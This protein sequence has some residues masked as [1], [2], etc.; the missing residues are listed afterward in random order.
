MLLSRSVLEKFRPPKERNAADWAESYAYLPDS[1]ANRGKFHARPYQ[2]EILRAMSIGGRRLHANGAPINELILLKSVQVGYTQMVFNAIGY[3]IHQR[4]CPIGFYVP[5]TDTAQTFGSK[6]F[7]K[8]LA[9]QKILHKLVSDKLSNDGKSSTTTKIFPSGYFSI[10]SANKSADVASSSMKLIFGDEIDKYEHLI[11]GEGKP[12]ELIRNRA[13]EH[14]D[15]LVV[16]GSTPR[17]NYEESQIYQLY[18]GSDKRRFHVRCP[19]CNHQQYLAWPQ[20][21]PN[22]KN[23]YRESGFECIKCNK[24]FHE[25][26]KYEMISQGQWIGRKDK[27]PDMVPGRAGFYIWAAYSFSPNLTWPQIARRY[28][29]CNHDKGKRIDFYNNVVGLPSKEK[30]QGTVL[31]TEITAQKPNALYE[32]THPP[33]GPVMDLPDDVNLITVGVDYQTSKKNPR[34]EY[35]FWGYGPGGNCYFMG[36]REIKGDPSQ[37]VV[38]DQLEEETSV[39]FVSADN[40]RTVPVSVLFIDSRGGANMKVY[41]V[42]RKP[43]GIAR[44]W[45]IIGVSHYNK[46]EM[47]TASVTGMQPKQPLYVVNTIPIKNHISELVQEL[48][49]GDPRA[50]LHIPS[51]L[52]EYVAMG[53]VSEYKQISKTGRVSWSKIPSLANEPLDCFVYSFAAKTLLMT[54]QDEGQFWS[55]LIK[56]NSGQQKPTPQR[57]TMSQMIDFDS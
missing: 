11:K 39:A 29:Q 57:A 28:N 48:C 41:E 25:K 52:S 44:W 14:A 45:P 10:L 31:Y 17:G 33:E 40:K 34:L 15:K 19:H 22:P 50:K 54:G 20:F 46:P 51:N 36:H 2:H 5:T 18:Q 43:H 8:W 42:C 7:A 6:Y 26:H 49:S 53:W 35:S 27:T 30:P 1:D 38:W 24:L 32:A 9:A 37:N 47:V 56:Q 23:E 21:R 55:T 13:Q 16:F 12:L 4:P 3:H